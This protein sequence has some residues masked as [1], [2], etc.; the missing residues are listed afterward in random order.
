MP[1]IDFARVESFTDDEALERIAAARASRIIIDGADDN[2]D[3]TCALKLTQVISPEL[4][5]TLMSS[6]SVT[7]FTRCHPLIR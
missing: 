2:E 6:P 5:H 1:G 4:I 7:S 3:F